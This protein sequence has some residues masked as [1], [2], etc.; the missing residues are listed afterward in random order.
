M[1]KDQRREFI[2]NGLISLLQA[3][4]LRAGRSLN[5]VATRAGLSHAMVS[6]VEKRKRLPTIETLLRIAEAL[7][8]R[9]STA[10]AQAEEAAEQRSA[11]RKRTP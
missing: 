1:P 9:L 3:E 6:R 2:I 7:D 5:E 11:P 10:L 8:I 4:R